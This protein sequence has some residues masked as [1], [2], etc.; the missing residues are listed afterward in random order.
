MLYKAYLAIKSSMQKHF[1]MKPAG[2]PYTAGKLLYVRHRVRPT[3][4]CSVYERQKRAVS[5]ICAVVFISLCGGIFHS[6]HFRGLLAILWVY[7][8]PGLLR[9]R[10]M[11]IQ[12]YNHGI[13]GY[14][15]ESGTLKT[16]QQ[17]NETV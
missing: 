15:G 4:C 1:Y 2:M 6:N 7:P 14:L 8:I 5:H 13:S 10:S 16:Q 9:Q 11:V 3:P 12:W 17:K